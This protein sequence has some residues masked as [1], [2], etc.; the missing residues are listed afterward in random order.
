[1]YLYC[2]LHFGN[3]LAAPLDVPT[4][5]QPNTTHSYDANITWNFN[6][7]HSHDINNTW[8]FNNGLTASERTQV[9]SNATSVG[10]NSKSF[11]SNNLAQFTDAA[12]S[13]TAID[14]GDENITLELDCGTDSNNSFAAITLIHMGTGKVSLS[15]VMDLNLDG[16]PEYST[17]LSDIAGI[18][19]D[20]VYQ[21]S[22]NN[23]SSATCTPHRVEYNASPRTLQIN[24]I[25]LPTDGNISSCYCV[26]GSCASPSD[27]KILEDIGGNIVSQLAIQ[28]HDYSFRGTKIIPVPPSKLEIFATKATGCG[29]S[30]A[31]SQSGVSYSTLMSRASTEMTTQQSDINSSFNMAKGYYDFNTSTREDNGTR[32]LYKDIYTQERN[33]ISNTDVNMTTMSFHYNDGHQ[34]V[35]GNSTQ[36]T[37]APP[38]VQYCKVKIPE[39]VD[40]IYSEATV[41]NTEHRS[42][43]KNRYTYER[44]KCTG[45]LC[46]T[47][48]S[49]TVHRAC[50]TKQ[51]NFEEAAAASAILNGATKDMVCSSD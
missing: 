10:S 11:F 51:N 36:N 50:A 40:T 41:T 28:E 38:A 39:R 16:T 33:R 35:D 7:S 32:D 15:I 27:R 17:T 21:C 26:L 9:E 12:R 45:S 25:A 43:Y 42:G 13:G 22:T 31:Q 30:T 34:T 18:C 19:A 20:A 23:W 49:E 1:M 2:L 14:T 4:T 47:S 3:M 8:I 29:G 24:P 44:R 37:Y 5:W 6:A 48:G 46:P